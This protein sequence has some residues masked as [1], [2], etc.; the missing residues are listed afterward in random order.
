MLLCVEAVTVEPNMADSGSWYCG[1]A[2]AV[3]PGSPPF[4]FSADFGL[5]QCRILHTGVDMQAGLD[6]GELLVLAR[7]AKDR[8][9]ISMHFS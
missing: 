6:L 8:Y 9:A 4:R 7:S 2:A 1:G 3:V 5:M